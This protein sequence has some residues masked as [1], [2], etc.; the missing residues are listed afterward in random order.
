MQNY[1]ALVMNFDFNCHNIQWL[2]HSFHFFH[3]L[4]S[5][6]AKKRNRC[7]FIFESSQVF[8]MHSFHLF[9][10]L[11]FACRRGY[12]Y[13]KVLRNSLKHSRKFGIRHESLRM[14]FNFISIL[15][16]KSNCATI[17]ELLSSQITPESACRGWSDHASF[18]YHVI[19]WLNNLSTRLIHIVPS[20]KEKMT[21]AIVV[22]IWRK[23]KVSRPFH[24]D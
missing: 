5:M 18:N 13:M 10:R 22:I 2:K 14:K 1:V 8:E 11:I 7:I 15:L 19:L 20:V 3:F 12:I 21:I 4:A 6:K 23:V 24:H 16:W 17:M 9:K